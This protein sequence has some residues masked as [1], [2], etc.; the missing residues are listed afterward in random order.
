MSV[1]AMS[2]Q[3]ADPVLMT[4]DGKDVHVSEFEYLYDKNNNQQLE[5]QTLDQYLDMF[6]VYKL[7]VAD[8]EHAG[9]DRSESF[10]K[11]FDKFR[12]ELSAPYLIDNDVKEQLIQ[13]SFGH[14]K[15]EVTV[16]HIMM[17][18]KDAA[19]TLD[20]LRTASV[21]GKTTFEDAARTYSIDTPSAR[22]GGLM[23]FVTPGRFP[24]PFEKAAY[25]T[26]VGQISPV[27]NSGMGFHLI[28]VESIKPSEGEVNAAH[29]LLMT[30]GKKD[31]EIEAQHQLID[32]IYNVIKAGAD[33]A[34]MAKK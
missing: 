16:S 12:K 10:I 2:A 24:W 20:S 15:N 9:I 22:R 30:R 34:E 17:Q 31:D 13:E 32:S 21:E 4:V 5:P 3:K 18:G 8:A 25:E 26:A 27:V 14:R 6:A 19:H 11:E 7:K 29:I 1:A 28:R 33:F 23:G